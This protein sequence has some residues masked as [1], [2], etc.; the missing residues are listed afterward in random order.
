[1][2][3]ISKKDSYFWPV[4]VQTPADGGTFK[5]EKFDAELKFLSQT[6][7]EEI[8][9]QIAEDRITDVEL[10]REVW[11]GWKG[12]NDSDGNDIL[13]SESMRDKLLDQA[14]VATA[15]VTALIESLAGA[16][17]KN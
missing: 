1:M 10:A 9:K 7:I 8:K 16:R 14:L 11:I 15:V 17:R 13:Y 2:F 12:I 3:V 4:T 6:R 5:R